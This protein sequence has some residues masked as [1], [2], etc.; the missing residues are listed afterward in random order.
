MLEWIKTKDY[1]P[2]KDILNVLFSV[3]NKTH[4]GYTL[5]DSL[6]KGFW[7]LDEDNLEEGGRYYGYDVD[8]WMPLPKPYQEEEGLD[9]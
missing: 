4:Y 6:N 7:A 9:D 5:W 2:G 1:L 3:D 8:A